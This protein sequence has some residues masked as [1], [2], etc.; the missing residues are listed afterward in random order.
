VHGDS[1]GA[2]QMAI[3]VRRALAAAGVDLRPFA[4]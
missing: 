1:P 3:A 2:V 4:T